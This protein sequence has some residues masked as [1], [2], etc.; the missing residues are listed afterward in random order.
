MIELTE[1]KRIRL[2]DDWSPFILQK[3]LTLYPDEI[4]V[5]NN[6]TFTEGAKKQVAV[7]A[8]ERNPT[9]RRECIIKKSTICIICGFDFGEFYGGQF[10]GKIHVHHLNTIH[11]QS[12]EYSL[13]P[14]T[15]LI[16][17]YPNC[18][19]ILHSK[20]GGV[21]TIDEVK[22]F[23]YDQR[24]KKIQYNRGTKIKRPNGMG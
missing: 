19:M 6:K 1:N 2:W 17:V 5:Q 7:N 18:H 14:E 23:I 15:D 22:K 11:L 20:L 9:A 12:E 10:N 8:Y 4:N 3:R 16:P 21:Y 24:N 13:N